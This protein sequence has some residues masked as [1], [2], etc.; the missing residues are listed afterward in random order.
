[1][2]LDREKMQAPL[3]YR[4]SDRVRHT[5]FHVQHRLTVGQRL[6]HVR[7]EFRSCGAENLGEGFAEML[8]SRHS[9]H[10]RKFV[11]YPGEATFAV[12]DANGCGRTVGGE[13]FVL[14]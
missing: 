2:I 10:R 8:R 5:D 11:V 4:P 14:G 3:H 13:E 7:L 9:T 6:L 12:Q 1:M